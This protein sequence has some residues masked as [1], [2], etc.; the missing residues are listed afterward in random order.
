MQA[1]YNEWICTLLYTLAMVAHSHRFVRTL[2]FHWERYCVRSLD[3]LGL[4]LL[5]LTIKILVNLVFTN[6]IH[7]KHIDDGK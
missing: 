1:V 6:T 3:C 5:L 7:G 2:N 4:V